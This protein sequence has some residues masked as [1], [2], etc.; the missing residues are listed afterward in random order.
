MTSLEFR[1]VAHGSPNYRETVR[2]RDRLLR[3]PLGLSFSASELDDEADDRHLAGFDTTTGK[4]VACL[5][6]TPVEDGIVK[7][8]Q[9]A[10]EP[11]LQGL[12]WGRLL[13]EFSERFAVENRIREIVLHARET[14]VGFYL[15]LGYAIEGAPFVEVTIPHRR[16][17]KRLVI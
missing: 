2:L 17:R 8:R 1:E 16:M 13:V 14:V 10:V 9:V 3:A 4:L 12:G 15:K 6:L 7:M 5:V 11:R